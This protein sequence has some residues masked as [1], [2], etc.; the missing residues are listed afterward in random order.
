MHGRAV[1]R[2][3]LVGLVGALV[4]VLAAWNNLVVTRLPAGLRWG[5]LCIAVVAA[6][7]TRSSTRR[8]VVPNGGGGQPLGTSRAP[9]PQSDPSRARVRTR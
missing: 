8:I 7:D 4:A 1:C 3:R 6:R 9:Y 5:G 2:R